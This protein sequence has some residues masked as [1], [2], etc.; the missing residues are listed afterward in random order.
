MPQPDSKAA[1]ARGSAS[2]PIGDLEVT[3]NEPRPGQI[4]ALR[5]IVKLM[6]S[7]DAVAMGQGATLFL[8]IAD[9]LVAEDDVLQQIYE[10]MATES[11]Q[12]EQYSDLLVGALK[13][14]LP[15]EE[16]GTEAIKGT[17]RPAS[18]A[19]S[20]RRPAGKR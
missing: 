13:H 11:L 1:A 10:G 15:E 19:Q 7:G 2:F 16:E 9:T 12:L 14:F 20:T 3:L 6:E 17:R 8:D 4:A 18:R 5:R